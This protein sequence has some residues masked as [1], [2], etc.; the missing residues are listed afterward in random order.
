MLIKL[1]RSLP[2]LF[3]CI[4][5]KFSTKKQAK[6]CR[7]LQKETLMS[8][9]FSAVF[10]LFFGLCV[11]HNNDFTTPPKSNGNNTEYID[12]SIYKQKSANQKNDY[13]PNFATKKPNKKRLLTRHKMVHRRMA[14]TL[15][16]LEWEF[17]KKAVPTTKQVTQLFPNGVDENINFED[18][19]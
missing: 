5:A 3:V 15:E 18:V 12:A 19:D 1:L 13:V 2:F 7:T 16:M 11:T 6:A 4:T 8:S 17:T 10:K 14:I 9:L